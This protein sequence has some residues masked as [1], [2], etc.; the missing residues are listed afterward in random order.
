MSR[1]M[2]GMIVVLIFS[3]EDVASRSCSGLTLDETEEDTSL[4]NVSPLE[5]AEQRF[6][7][8]SSPTEDSFWLTGRL[9]LCGTTEPSLGALVG[10][11]VGLPVRAPEI[12]ALFETPSETTLDSMVTGTGVL[13][14]CDCISVSVPLLGAQSGPVRTGA[15]ASPLWAVFEEITPL[16][17]TR[18][19]CSV[20]SDDNLGDGGDFRRW[21]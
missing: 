6:V 9:V 20:S 5:A 19:L 18:E 17:S 15:G 7:M 2:S 12:G 16:D 14:L 3:V 8:D 21:P 13:C 11:L 1:G 4:D 10:A